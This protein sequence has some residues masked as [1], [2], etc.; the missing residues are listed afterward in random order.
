MPGAEF[1]PGGEFTRRLFRDAGLGEGMRVLDVGCGGGVVTRLVAELVGPS[2]VVGIDREAS[3]IEAA[4]R[5]A[6][7]IVFRQ[8]DLEA[9]PE[10]LG[11]FDAVVGRRVLTYLPNAVGVIRGLA[12]HLRPGG[13]MVFHEHDATL[14][15]ASHVDLPLHAKAFSWIREMLTS[16]GANLRMGLDLRGTFTAAGITVEH[17]RAEAIVQT[18]EQ[19][20]ALGRLIRVV[21]PRL[22]GKGITTAEDV[23]VETLEARLDE[24]R[25]RTNTTILADMMFGLIGRK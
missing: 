17:V 11:L 4:Q 1:P 16:E 24:E 2:Q 19:P 18:P 15:S 5:G 9:L 3:A 14:C 21:L 8:C 22:L 6:P 23:D 7:D 13:L 10:D 25:A 20:Y 12:E